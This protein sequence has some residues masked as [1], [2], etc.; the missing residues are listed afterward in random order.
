MAEGD[1]E[2]ADASRIQR[3]LER[4]SYVSQSAA[5]SAVQQYLMPYII[6]VFADHDEGDLE[7]MILANYD[8]VKQQTPAGIKQALRNLGSNPRLREQYADLVVTLVTPANV[9]EWLRNPEEWLE[10][11]EADEQR[12]RLKACADVIEETPGGEVWLE[13]QIMRLY[14]YAQIVPEQPDTAVAD[15]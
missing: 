4:L 13:A 10:A 6:R 15:D 7:R 8:L 1:T 11:E 12:E 2:P 5:M 3:T 14:E 9:K